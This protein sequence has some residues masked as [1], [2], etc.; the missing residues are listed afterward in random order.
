MGHYNPRRVS[1]I[2]MFGHHETYNHEL[3][4]ATNASRFLPPPLLRRQGYFILFIDVHLQ[5]GEQVSGT[6]VLSEPALGEGE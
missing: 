3:P 6:I 4:Q 5:P 2:N 1:S